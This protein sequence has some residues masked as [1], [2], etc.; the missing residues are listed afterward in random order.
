MARFCEPFHRQREPGA[1]MN[2]DGRYSDDLSPGRAVKIL[3]DAVEADEPVVLFPDA[4]RLILVL[5]KR[6]LRAEVREWSSSRLVEGAVS[7]LRRSERE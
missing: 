2:D 6:G 1:T 4:S 5:A 3:Q 7:D